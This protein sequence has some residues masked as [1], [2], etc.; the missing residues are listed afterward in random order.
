MIDFCY[1]IS[2]T[3][4]DELNSDAACFCNYEMRFVFFKNCKKWTNIYVDTC[5]G[6]GAGDEGALDFRWSKPSNYV[7]Q[8]ETKAKRYE[9]DWR[10]M[11]LLPLLRRCI[12][13]SSSPSYQQ[14]CFEICK[15]IEERIHY[16]SIGWTLLRFAV[17]V[18]WQKKTNW[19]IDWLIDCCFFV[20]VFL[21]PSIIV[22]F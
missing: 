15:M 1:R 10:R 17:F 8:F 12:R 21:P 7:I 4:G 19:L 13:S 20:I 5:G 6:N 11:L 3:T 9:P 22:I 2:L 14:R 18:C 16:W